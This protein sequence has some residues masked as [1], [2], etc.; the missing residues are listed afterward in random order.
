MFP[1]WALPLRFLTE[2]LCILL[3]SPMRDTCSI[4]T[5]PDVITLTK[6]V[7]TIPTKYCTLRGIS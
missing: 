7:Y 1:K 5:I 6:V 2:I 3:I 4:S